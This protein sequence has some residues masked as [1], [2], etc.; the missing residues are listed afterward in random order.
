MIIIVLLSVLFLETRR[1]KRCRKPSTP[2]A[3]MNGKRK[4][5]NGKLSTPSPLRGTPLS[6]GDKVNGKLSL[7]FHA[8]SK[9]QSLACPK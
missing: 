3:L 2:Y 4:S 8:K 5:E 1:R 9:K 7:T 6:Q